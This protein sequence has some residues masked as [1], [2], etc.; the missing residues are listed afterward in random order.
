MAIYTQY[1][2]YLKAKLF[3]EMLDSYGDTYMLLS[4]GNPQWDNV[5]SAQTQP[6]PAAPYNTTCLLESSADSPFMDNH[7]TQ[8]FISLTNDGAYKKDTVVDSSPVTGTLIN[9]CKDLNP[10]FPCIFCNFQE[11]DNVEI[12]TVGSTT[13][14]Q[15]NYNEFYI[16]EDSIE[17]TTHLYR[18]SVSG[19]TATV[20]NC[21]E[22]LFSSLSTSYERQYF[23]E[24]YLRGLSCKKRYRH[25]CGLLGAVKCSISFVK[26]IQN[27][28]YIGD[29]NQFWYGDRYWEIVNPLDDDLDRYITD[30]KPNQLVYPHHLL[31]NATVNPRQ[32]CDN[33]SYDQCISARHIALYTKK[34]LYDTNGGISLYSS[35]PVVYSIGNYIF[36]FGQ[37]TEADINNTS[38]VAGEDRGKVLNFTLPCSISNGSSTDKYP[39]GDFKFI[40]NDYIKG[41]IKNEHSVDRFGYILGF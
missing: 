5:G 27:S 25:P 32:L 10:P 23:V 34:R 16:D 19:G 37:Y 15:N 1:G 40:L 13:V 22:L 33:L 7:V 41:S 4:L 35:G 12:F 9:R 30:S 18:I 38:I 3:K 24:L 36:N 8:S 6:M 20:S 39:D 17:H 21:G 11:G 14:T 29:A 31:F 2:R 26:D 28:E